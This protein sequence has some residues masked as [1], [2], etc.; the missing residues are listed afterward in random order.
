LD[1]KINCLPE[2]CQSQLPDIRD[3]TMFD[4]IR[5]VHDDVA[6]NVDVVDKVMTSSE[7]DCE[8]ASSEE[9]VETSVCKEPPHHCDKNESVMLLLITSQNLLKLYS[10]CNVK[11][12]G[13]G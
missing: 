2:E 9:E 6:G 10:D 5:E 3:V 7:T 1:D 8:E 12:K 13:N 4:I 11:L